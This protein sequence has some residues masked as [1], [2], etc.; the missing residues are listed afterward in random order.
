MSGYSPSK[1][2]ASRIEL[3]SAGM[4]CSCHSILITRSSCFL[5]QFSWIESYSF[6]PNGEDYRRHLPGQRK[7]CHRRLHSLGQQVSVKLSQRTRGTAD[8]HGSA[9]EQ[10]FQVMVMIHVQAAECRRLL[11]SLQFARTEAVLTARS[12]LQR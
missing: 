8:V 2:S 1:P 6:P 10:I 12:C 4:P 7:T 5:F 11:G 9:F 3:S